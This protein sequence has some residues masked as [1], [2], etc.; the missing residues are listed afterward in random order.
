MGMLS[1]IPRMNPGFGQ[2]HSH[3]GRP[4]QLRAEF[5]WI[6]CHAHLNDDSTPVLGH[7]H[8]LGAGE[9]DQSSE[10]ILRVFRA[11]GMHATPRQ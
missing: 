10:A 2:N 4:R 3:K 5:S 11:Q 8:R 7:R 6:F 9:V 1:D